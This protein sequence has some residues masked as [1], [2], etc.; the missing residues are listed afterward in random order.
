MIERSFRTMGTEVSVWV[1]ARLDDRLPVPAAIA[2]SVEEELL[3]FSR[4]LS[5]FLPGSELT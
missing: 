1:G 4:R 2:A 3:D 5:R